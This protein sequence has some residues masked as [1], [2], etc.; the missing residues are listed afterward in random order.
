ME[1]AGIADVCARAAALRAGGKTREAIAALNPA[2]DPDLDEPAPLLESLRLCL[3]VGE[4]EQAW[5]LYERIRDR[6]GAAGLSGGANALARLQEALAGREIPEL[7]DPALG[8]HA[9]W[10]DS[11]L[12]GGDDEARPW[13]IDRIRA[14]CPGG[15]VAYTLGGR[16]PWCDAPSE[17]TARMSLMIDRD[18][19][20]PSCFGRVRLR[21]DDAKEFLE[22]RHPGL[23]SGEALD[24]TPAF[25]R[26][27]H[28][29]GAGPREGS[30][31]PIAAHY[32]NQQYAFFLSQVFTDR[33]L[34]GTE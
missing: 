4:P 31:F 27:F 3:L 8:E 2:L 30:E 32:L 25:L 18:W 11:V 16:C 1:P 34:E 24:R 6:H 21:F 10:V 26:L 12:A 17:A 23:V 22:R 5:S 9:A 7:R 13:A 28:D 14:R 15:S 20:C 19:I 29:L 33:S